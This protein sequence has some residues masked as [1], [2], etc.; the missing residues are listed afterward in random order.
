M[1]ADTV[2]VWTTRALWVLFVSVAA[3]L[4][5]FNNVDRKWFDFF[6]ELVIVYGGVIRFTHHFRRPPI[7][8]V[9]ITMLVLHTLVAVFLANY[10][11]TVP[12]AI[13]VGGTIAEFIG[14]GFVLML[15]EAALYP[16]KV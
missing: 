7:W 2:K 10:I 1:M 11:D 9:W 14:V 4:F 8:G 12:R 15:L 13:M 6:V 16:N 5:L 3:V